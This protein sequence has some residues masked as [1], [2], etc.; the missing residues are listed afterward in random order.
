[1]EGSAK[2]GLMQSIVIIAAG[3]GGSAF[4]SCLDSVFPKRLVPSAGAPA[5]TVL[6]S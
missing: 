3:D 5:L 6:S 1:M 4:F 2:E